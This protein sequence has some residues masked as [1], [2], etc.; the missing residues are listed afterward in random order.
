MTVTR[1]LLGIDPGLQKMGWGV[2]DV[3]GNR[4]SHV[5]HGTVTSNA[6]DELGQRLRSLFEGI[7]EVIETWRPEEA[8][9]EVSFVTTGSIAT[10]RLG[11]ARGIAMVVPTLADLDVYEY[12][13]KLVKKSVVGKGNA[14]KEQVHHMISLLMP[15]TEVKG[16][17]AADALA[18]A[19]CHAHHSQGAAAVDR[20]RSIVKDGV[21]KKRTSRSGVGHARH[22]RTG[23][24]TNEDILARLAK[25]KSGKRP[26]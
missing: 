23:K 10:M 19:I 17:D 13:P 15:G 24:L 7:T 3:T 6:K 9:V 16:T 18:I 2:I 21:I 20:T 11:Q 4:L 8:A 22:A 14:A 12:D 1:R 25:G 26:V 5:A